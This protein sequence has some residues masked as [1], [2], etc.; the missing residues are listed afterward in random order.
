MDN[1]RIGLKRVAVMCLLRCE[2]EYLLLRRRKPPFIDCYVPV[3]G[4]VEPF[5][6][7]SDAVVR[8]VKEETTITIRSPTL[9]GVLTETS[10]TDFNWVSFI[11]GTTINKTV[12]MP[13]DEGM[14]EWV[15]TARLETIPMPET[16]AYIFNLAQV[17][18]RMQTAAGN[19]PFLLNAHYDKD[20]RLTL[21]SNETNGHVLYR[22]MQN[23]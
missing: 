21:L 23:D 10:S 20:L 3:G 5:E 22:M 2:H 11:Y 14:L 18:E 12:P 1:R 7:P 8:E 15:H 16:D 13:C 6:A 9:L 17:R 4:K 19:A